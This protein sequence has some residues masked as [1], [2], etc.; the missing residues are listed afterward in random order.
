MKFVYLTKQQDSTS[1]RGDRV[2]EWF[3]TEF[4]TKRPVT[5]A[6]AR[7][8]NGRSETWKVEYLTGK[9]TEIQVFWYADGY[10][11]GPNGGWQSVIYALCNVVHMDEVKKITPPNQP[12]LSM[13]LVR[14]LFNR[15]DI[16]VVTECGMPFFKDT[17]LYQFERNRGNMIGFLGH[18]QNY[19]YGSYSHI[20]KL[21]DRGTPGYNRIGPQTH[22]S[23]GNTLYYRAAIGVCRLFGIS[24][25]RPECM[26]SALKQ[27]SHVIQIKMDDEPWANLNPD[28]TIVLPST[29]TLSA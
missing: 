18:L 7:F 9:V 8:L 15:H 26:E 20:Q 24:E 28:G 19:E 13:V 11:I 17:T 2:D 29:A 25:F 1:E 22:R 27:T 6:E 4:G 14:F 10:Y 3:T 21:I 23:I 16:S 5:I 12:S